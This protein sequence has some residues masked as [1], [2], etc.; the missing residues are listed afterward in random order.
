MIIRILGEGQ[1]DVAD[2]ALDELNELDNALTR[3]I[4]SDDDVAFRAALTTL[5]D[6]V[7]QRGAP[8]PADALV[9]SQ[10]IL[11]AADAHLDEVKDLLGEEGLIP[12]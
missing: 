10:L 7:R 11:P 1:F 5:L 9:P 3:A 12:G 8:A 4:D 2:D 6:T